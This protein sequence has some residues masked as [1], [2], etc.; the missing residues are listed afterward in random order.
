ML[1]KAN[2][3]SDEQKEEW[4]QTLKL[5]L[6]SSDESGIDNEESEE[7]I[8]TK[9]LPWRST[10]LDEFFRR[11]DDESHQKKSPQARR[12]MKPRRLGVQSSRP[13][14]DR[15]GLPDWVFC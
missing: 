9:P 10:K 2:F 15:E 3:E 1:E 7:V 13:P 4:R 6:I 12:Q 8:I 5:E 11:L 14:P